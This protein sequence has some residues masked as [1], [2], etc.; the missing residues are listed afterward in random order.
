M[1]TTSIFNIIVLIAIVLLISVSLGILYLTTVEWQ[2]RRRQEK[3]KR[4]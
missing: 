1:E 2:D 3:D 4:L